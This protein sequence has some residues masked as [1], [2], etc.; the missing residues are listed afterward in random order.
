M[1]KIN[2]KWLLK[3]K[4]GIELGQ[5]GTGNVYYMNGLFLRYWRNIGW[6]WQVGGTENMWECLHTPTRD[7]VCTVLHA[8][9]GTKP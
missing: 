7:F 3:M 9:R 1:S 8:L 5:D 4:F 2:R 6:R